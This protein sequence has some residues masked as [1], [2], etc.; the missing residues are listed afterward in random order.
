MSLVPGANRAEPSPVSAPRGQDALLAQFVAS[1]TPGINARAYLE[2]V[3]AELAERHFAG[4]SGSEI[5]AAMTAAMDD[6]LRALFQYADAEHGR[7][8]PK[9]N[10]KLAVVAR[11]GY[12]RGEL[13]PQSDVDLL[14]LHDYKRGPYAEIV[15][16]IILHALWDAG[17]IVGHGVRTAKECVRLANDDLKEKTAILDARFLCGDEKLYADLDKLLIAEVLNRNQDK[18]FATKLEESRKRHAQYGD[19]IYLLEPQIKEGEGGLRDLHT[20]MWLAKV[21]YKVHSLE[22]LVQKAVITEPEAAEVIEARDFLWRVRNSLHFLTGRH[23]DQMTFELQERI[24]PLLGFKPRGGTDRG[25]RPDARVLPARID[26]PSLRRRPDRARH[27][28]H[29]RRTIFSTHTDPQDSPRRDSPGQSAE[30]RR[31]RLFQARSDRADQNLRRLPGAE[32]QPLG[33]HV[34]A[35]ARQPGLDR[36]RPAQR[37]ARRA[38]R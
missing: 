37:P 10:Q 31:A 15:T 19:S 9:L 36:R 3:R 1:K 16:E 34:P 5:T 13:N 30:H 38:R 11:G 23:F 8:A 2:S 18:F 26:D 29:G 24:E 35:G 20:A 4:A 7:R 28:E 17:L 21:K 27:R 25:F 12:G 32:R 6:L 33:Q 22:E 14:F